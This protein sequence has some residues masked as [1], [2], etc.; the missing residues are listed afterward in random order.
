[1]QIRHSY[2][3]QIS[4]KV[5]KQFGSKSKSEQKEH[6]FFQKMF[7][8]SNCSPGHSDCIF[9]KSA[10]FFLPK[11]RKV[12]AQNTIIVKTF[13]FFKTYVPTTYSPG[14]TDF[15]FDKLA[16]LFGPKVGQFFA[17]NVQKWWE[18]MSF[19]PKTIIETVFCRHKK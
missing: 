7:Y 11:V 12:F 10:E 5:L 13:F 16:E 6:I 8:F 2:W 19:F 17:D 1:M 14:H 3:R 4:V 18:E 9:D 15:N